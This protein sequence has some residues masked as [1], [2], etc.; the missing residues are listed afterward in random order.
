MTTAVARSGA[1]NAEDIFIKHASSTKNADPNKL[2]Q[3]FSRCQADADGRITV[4]TLI[5]LAHQHGADFSKWRD[6]AQATPPAQLSPLPFSNMSNWDNE[7]VPNREWAV[8][9]RIPLRQLSLFSGEGGAGKSYMTLHLCVAH[10]LGRE[11]LGSR[12]VPGP[13][14]FWDAEDDESE[15]RIRLNSILKHYGATHADLVKGGFHLMSFVGRDS[16]LA[17]VSRGGKVEPTPLYNQL[18]QAAGDIKPKMIGVAS[19]ANIFAGNEIERTQVQQ[20]VSLLTRIAQTANGSIQL[21]SHPSLAG[22]NTGT[23]LSGSTQWHNAVR[24][25]SYLKSV[26]STDGEQPDSDLRELVFKKVQYG[27]LPDSIILCYQNGMFLPVQGALSLDKAAQLETA[28]KVFLT[29]LQQYDVANR[30]VSDKSGRSYAPALFA[31]ED[32]AKIA[33]LHAKILEVA[34]RGPF[35]KERKIWN[36][37]SGKPSATHIS[38]CKGRTPPGK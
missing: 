9:D 1:P 16:V 29:T 34:M 32:E 26:T 14:M 28:K 35:F 13:A 11:W 12:P 24:A 10:A 2:R 8:P 4:G 18:L 17:T 31:R 3:Y 25:R 33:G 5:H 15:I 21:I 23:G 19:S 7:P 20:F 22:I 6:R 36:E 38:N 27:G 30:T 37:P